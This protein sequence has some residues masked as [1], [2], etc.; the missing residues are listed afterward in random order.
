[1]SGKPG[2][3]AYT[4]DVASRVA[5]ELVERIAD[6]CVRVEIAGS[7]RRKRPTVRDIDIVCVPKVAA[8]LDM[9]GEMTST[10]IDLLACRLDELCG[11]RVIVQWRGKNMQTCWGPRLKRGTYR[12]VD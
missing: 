2:S 10:G 7:I 11:Q 8:M 6:T 3:A 4:L 5:S 12:G 9:F 1:M